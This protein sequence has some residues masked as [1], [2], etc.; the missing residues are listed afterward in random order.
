MVAN[1]EKTRCPARKSAEGQP[2]AKQ[3]AY[4]PLGVCNEQVPPPEGKVC[5]ELCRNAE[6]LAEM[7]N[8]ISVFHN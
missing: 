8:P 2:R 3:E 4:E 1:S 6:R 5:S 7:T